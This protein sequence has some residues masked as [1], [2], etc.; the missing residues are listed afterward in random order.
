MFLEQNIRPKTISIEARNVKQNKW[1]EYA[2]MHKADG[3]GQKDIESFAYLAKYRYYDTPSVHR[4]Y[5]M[6]RKTDSLVSVSNKMDGIEVIRIKTLIGEQLLNTNAINILREDYD[7]N[8][9]SICTPG[10]SANAKVISNKNDIIKY[11]QQL[12]RDNNGFASFKFVNDNTN[13]RWGKLK[14]NNGN[15]FHAAFLKKQEAVEE[16][17]TN[18]I[19]NDEWV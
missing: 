5:I 14:C 15:I 3:W 6:A 8:D 16:Q 7:K 4:M 10:N 17:S 9:L 18:E 19:L 12:S 2:R 11:I 13:I 1:F